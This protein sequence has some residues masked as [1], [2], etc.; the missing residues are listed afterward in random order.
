M[1]GA[2]RPALAVNP[3]ALSKGTRWPRSSFEGLLRELEPLRLIYLLGPSDR[4][5]VIPG[6]KQSTDQSQLCLLP[7][8]DAC[9]RLS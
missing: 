7:R 9:S 6:M 8:T 3:L 1:S 4:D 5:S 2:D